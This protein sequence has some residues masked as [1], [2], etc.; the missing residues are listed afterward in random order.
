MRSPRAQTRYPMPLDPKII[1]EAVN[2]GDPARAALAALIAFH[3]LRNGE[4][5]AV[6]LTDF[7]DGRLILPDRTILLAAPVRE[8]IA[9]WLDKRSRLFPET[10]N[11]HLFVNHYTAVRL[12]PVSRGW[13][14]H[15]HRIPA[16]AIREDRILQEALATGG[17]V[18]RL[19]DLFGLSVEG[20]ERYAHTTDQP[21]TSI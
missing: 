16:Q 15:T 4:L 1:R 19:G 10:T 6:L 2:S 8:R 11:P 20:A 12:G 13:I 17:D 9:A 14:S 21:E 7:S 18:H 5:R 3:G